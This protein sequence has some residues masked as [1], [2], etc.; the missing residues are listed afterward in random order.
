MWPVSAAAFHLAQGH[1]CLRWLLPSGYPRKSGCFRQH[2]L[3][4]EAG[5]DLCVHPRLPHVFTKLCHILLIGLPS[6][7]VLASAI[8]SVPVHHSIRSGGT[9]GKLPAVSGGGDEKEKCLA[10][11]CPMGE[12]NSCRDVPAGSRRAT[13]E[14]PVAPRTGWVTTQVRFGLSV[15]KGDEDL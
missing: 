7:Y 3:P 15:Y 8:T 4:H 10:S 13:V 6:F 9:A 5:L 11:I 1:S 12:R 14:S 2:F